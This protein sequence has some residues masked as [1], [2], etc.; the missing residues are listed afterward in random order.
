M[1]SACSLIPLEFASQIVD[2]RAALSE[3]PV[4]GA[5][6]DPPFAHFTHQLA[7]DYDWDGLGEALADFAAK[8]Q[9]F[10]ARTSGLLCFTGPNSADVAVAVFRSPDLLAHHA[11]LWHVLRPFAR[12]RVNDFYE[13]QNLVPHITIKRCGN[14]ADRFGAAMAKLAQRNFK[15][16]MTIDNVSVQCDPANNSQTHF[17]RLTYALGGIERQTPAAPEWNAIMFDV[18][19]VSLRGGAIAYDARAHNKDG[20]ETLDRWSPSRLV[21]LMADAC[22]SWVYFNGGRCRVEGGK[23]VAVEPKTPQPIVL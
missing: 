4:I 13:P 9:P 20:T 3:D 23:I 21:R 8:H 12:G 18:S 6:Y 15:W 19:Q 1:Q 5:I 11:A 10:E 16:S 22:A 17:Q 2:A 7:E 14:D